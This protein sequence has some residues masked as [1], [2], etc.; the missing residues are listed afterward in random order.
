MSREEPLNEMKLTHGSVRMTDRCCS[1]G[2]RPSDG[3]LGS[4]E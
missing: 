1:A 3:A 2:S 4:K